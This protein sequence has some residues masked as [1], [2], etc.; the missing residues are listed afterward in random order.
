MTDEERW[1][2]RSMPKRM[3]LFPS[4]IQDNL[5]TLNLKSISKPIE[6]M[7]LYGQVGSGKTTW[8]AHL[9]LEDAR[10]RYLSPDRGNIK[11]SFTNLPELLYT[12]RSSYDNNE[13]NDYDM[14]ERYSTIDFLVLDD[15]GVQKITDWSFERLY[16]LINRRYDSSPTKTT[17]FTS[18]F[19]LEQI[20]DELGDDRLSSRIQ[21]MCHIQKF[22]GDYRT[23]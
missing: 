14:M 7:Y 17:I 15:L 22:E 6:S 9:M 5:R 16:L 1:Y 4:R 18:N 3:E 13:L 10:Q 20:A 8:A 23:S 11:Y 2:N 12:F 19:S 21:H